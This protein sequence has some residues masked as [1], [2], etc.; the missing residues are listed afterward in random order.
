MPDTKNYIHLY[1]VPEKAKINCGDRTAVTWR[2][3]EGLAERE[4]KGTF[5]DDRDVLY[6]VLSSDYM[7]IHSCQTSLHQTL[8]TSALYVNYTTITEGSLTN[9]A[10]LLIIVSSSEFL[11]KTIILKSSSSLCRI[12]NMLLKNLYYFCKLHHNMC[13]LWVKCLVQRWYGTKPTN[14]RASGAI[15]LYW[16]TR[17]S[18]LHVLLFCESVQM[19]AVCFLLHKQSHR[20][21]GSLKDICFEFLPLE[22]VRLYADS[23]TPCHLTS[24]NP[25][26]ISV[27]KLV[28][29]RDLICGAWSWSSISLSVFACMEIRTLT[30]ASL[31]LSSKQLSESAA[32]TYQ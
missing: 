21:Q 12:F 22:V 24:H 7:G 4:Q 13:I 32:G 30:L 23:F 11:F 10:Y 14:D 6:L 5:W 27:R 18:W 17:G 31:A 29:V 28:Q 3:E 15:R 26:H 2:V 20:F 19:A 1:E 8:K 25:A 16:E 9:I